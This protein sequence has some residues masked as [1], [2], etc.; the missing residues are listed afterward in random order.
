MSG[1][2]ELEWEVIRGYKDTDD[3]LPDSYQLSPSGCSSDKDVRCYLT[4]NASN[5]LKQLGSSADQSAQQTFA[6]FIKREVVTEVKK[7]IEAASPRLTDYIFYMADEPEVYRKHWYLPPHVLRTYRDQIR[8]VIPKGLTAI[9]YGPVHGNTYFYHRCAESLSGFHLPFDS[10]FPLSESG[11]INIDHYKRALDADGNATES[12]CGAPTL[13]NSNPGRLQVP[14]P[15]RDLTNLKTHIKAVVRHYK[16]H[17]D[18][19]MINSYAAINEDAANAAKIVQA[20]KEEDS[21]TPVW[22]WFSANDMNDDPND[23]RDDGRSFEEIRAQVYTAIA[24]EATGVMIYTDGETSSTDLNYAGQLAAAL[25]KDRDILSAA[26][27][28]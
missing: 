23:G 5:V 2:L 24:S 4:A 20:I 18:L 28:A 22:M 26:S 27:M 1:A 16:E 15:T 6:D 12:V 10:Q 25:H 17:T 14:H 8:A 7:D 11:N 19:H 21:D 13:P 3:A 9:G